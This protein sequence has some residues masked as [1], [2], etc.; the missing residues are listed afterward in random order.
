MTS[1]GYA[2]GQY[3]G[4]VPAH[5]PCCAYHTFEFCRS[6]GPTK[7]THLDAKR[8]FRARF[9]GRAQ[10]IPGIIAAGAVLTGLWEHRE[11]TMPGRWVMR[12]DYAAAGR[13]RTAPTGYVRH[14]A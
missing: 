1:P 7:D 3:S 10:G 14:D 6:S 8:A 12:S 9:P 2:A 13:A 5:P 4:I 11:G